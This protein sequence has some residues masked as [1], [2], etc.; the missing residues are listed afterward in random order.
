MK[1]SFIGLLATIALAHAYE[2]V[3]GGASGD[4]TTTRY[5]D[6][7]KASCSWPD[8]ADVSAPV[9]ACAVDGVTLVESN[10]QSGCSGG[11]AYMC[12]DNQPW[13][14]DED[15][16]YGFAAASLAGKDESGW[17]CG[18]YELTFTS[19]E[20]SGKKMVVQVTNTGGDLGNNHFDLQIPGGGIGIFNGC[21][22]QWDAPANGWGER[23]GGISSSSEC[24]NLPSK[25]QDGCKWRFDWFKNTNNPSI[26]F[27]EVSCPAELVK[28][29][30]CS[31][32]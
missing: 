23:Y 1:A 19:G 11:S 25:L 20:V 24:S 28:K 9:G 18:C 5:W 29:T 4:G 15:L 10:E 30:G 21:Q 17:C 26:T 27:K 32:T 8:K 7:C 14:V 12:I 3:S 13:A 2:A 6:C 31:R 22:T 16:S